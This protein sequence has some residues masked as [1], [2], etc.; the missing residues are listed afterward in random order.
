MRGS[1]AYLASWVM[2]IACCWTASAQGEQP[3]LVDRTLRSA[4]DSKW[5]LMQYQEAFD[6]YQVVTYSEMERAKRKGRPYAAELLDRTVECGLLAGRETE[7]AALLDSARAWGHA[8]DSHNEA[9]TQLNQALSGIDLNGNRLSQARVTPLRPSS[10]D[11]E[12]CAVPH[13]DAL[14][15]VQE[16]RA[17]GIGVDGWTG[18]K[19]GQVVRT[20]SSQPDAEPTL[21]DSWSK[22]HDGP[23]AFGQDGNWMLVTMSHDLEVEVA[24]ELKRNLKL[25]LFE[26][27]PNGV[28]VELKSFLHN[29]PEYSLAHGA[30]D[31]EDFLYFSSDMP[32]G[33]G[34]MDLWRCEVKGRRFGTPENLGPGVNTAAN[35]VFPFVGPDGT[36]YFSSS[37]HSGLGGLDLFAWDGQETVNLPSPVNSA[38]D[39]FAIHLDERGIGYVSSNR[40]NG[41]DRIYRL[42]MRDQTVELTYQLISCDAQPLEG[43]VIRVYNRNTRRRTELTANRAGAVSFEVVVGDTLDLTFKGG[44]VFERTQRTW[45][46]ELGVEAVALTDTVRY[47]PLDHAL[48]VRVENA[49]NNTDSV[50]VSFVCSDKERD[51]M[52]VAQNQPYRWGFEERPG[53]DQIV[54]DG[55]GYTSQTLDLSLDDACPRP[56]DFAVELEMAFDIDLAQV[57]YGLGKTKLDGRSRR[58][59]DEVVAYMNQAPHLILELSSHTD[60]RS[61]DAF[62]LELSQRRAQTC[63]DYIVAQG[64][65][66][67]RILAKGF[68]ES[69][70]LNHCVD[71]VPCTEAEHQQN[72]R[73]ELHFVGTR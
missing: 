58:V 72:R 34:G 39:D 16:R 7:L 70:P 45:A 56:H 55:I 59:L 68:G 19:Y 18:R 60:S 62:N 31:G 25:A 2:C 6:L 64:V 29:K 49:D 1:V 4:A 67:S 17:F 10:D 15:F 46:A 66:S 57:F 26:R 22:F 8:T 24:G 14:V 5:Q 71:G 61:S 12:Y 52:L 27:R 21:L 30:L 36:L 53:C 73:T 51:V 32:G 50:A 11:P 38:W 42:E 37:G 40:D 41:L 35:E 33:Y 63:V 13:E 54:V 65:E 69:R 9:W 28:W 3:K 20:P 43:E 23:V 48:T 44:D 47:Q